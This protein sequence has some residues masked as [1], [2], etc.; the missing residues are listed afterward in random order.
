MELDFAF[1]AS[2]A[3]LT[4]EGKLVSFGVGFDTMLANS[5]PAQVAPFSLVMKF[6]ALPSDL[7]MPHKFRIDCI[8]PSGEVT[9]AGENDIDKCP[10]VLDKSLPNGLFVLANIHKGIEKPGTYQ[11][12]IFLDG[13]LCKTIPFHLFA[14]SP[15]QLPNE[16][17]DEVGTDAEWKAFDKEAFTLD[18]FKA[19][20]AHLLST[21]KASA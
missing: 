2:Q 3:N 5:F 9:L 13:V 19:I 17:A 15:N 1:L 7:E 21:G 16:G 4:K 14:A 18:E 11:F 10:H 20:S 6:I 8:D 12:R